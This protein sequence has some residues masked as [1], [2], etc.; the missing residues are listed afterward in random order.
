MNKHLGSDFKEAYQKFVKG[1]RQKEIE[2]Q[3]MTAKLEV[4]NLL[5]AQ[6]ESHHLTQ[7]QLAD[8][9]GVKQQLV[10]RIESGANNITLDT[11]IRILTALGIALKVEKVKLER[12]KKVLQFV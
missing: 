4:A 12:A 7:K 8:K 5:T 9:L 6:R 11:L 10:S 3:V 1:D 2:I